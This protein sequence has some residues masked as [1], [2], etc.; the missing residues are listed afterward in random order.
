MKSSFKKAI[1]AFA[2]AIALSCGA[3]GFA[4]CVPKSVD[5]K[6]PSDYDTVT[7]VAAAP[8]DGSLPTAHTAAENLSYICGVFAKQTKYHSYS[9][10]QTVAMGV[11]Q[12]TRSWKDYSDGVLITSDITFSSMVKS[13]TQSC[14]VNYGKDSGT[15]FRTGAKAGSGVLCTTAEWSEEQPTYYDKHSY[16]YTYGMLPTELFNYI[17]NEDTITD[18][19]AATLNS[20]GTY[21]QEFTLD[22]TKSTYYI[23]FAMKTRGGLSGYPT[24]NKVSLTVTFTSSYEILHCSI[25]EN[26][27]LNK[28]FSM[29]SASTYE[30]DYAYGDEAAFYNENVKF[31]E[32]HFAY[33]ESFYKKYVN[34]SSEDLPQGGSSTGLTIDKTNVLANGFSDVLTKAG[35]QFEIFATLGQNKYVGYA[36]VSVP[37]TLDLSTITLRLS[38]GKTLSERGLYIEYSGGA[39]NAYY[40]DDFALAVNLAEV[41]TQIAGFDDIISRITSAV[42]E[43]S[44]ASGGL[45]LSSDAISRLMEDDMTLTAGTSQAIIAL[46]SD[47]L[48][49]LGIGIDAELV[50][51]INTDDIIFRGANVGGISV[52][53]EKLDINLAL[54][55]TTADIISFDGN[56]TP[57]S[58]ADYVADVHRLLSSDLL[59]I[60]VTLNG[61]G[62]SVKIPSLKGL[63]VQASAKVDIGGITL[64]AEAQVSYTYKNNAY[65]CA[66]EVWYGYNAYDE[67]A[68]G[69]GV[70]YVNLK[71]LNGKDVDFKVYCDVENIAS[72]L[73][74]L[75]SAAGAGKNATLAKILNG[76]LSTDF[77]SLIGG[78]YADGGKIQA[79]LSVDTA[80]EM[81]GVD[82]GVSFGTCALT[83]NKATE[84]TASNLFVELPAVGF[85]VTV[86]GAEGEISLPDKGDYLDLNVLLADVATITGAES[87][88]ADIA[89]DGSAVGVEGLAVT[90]AAYLDVS[91]LSAYVNAQVSYGN[92]SVQA[93][94][95]YRYVGKYGEAIISLD[96]VNGKSENLENVKI[97]CN[98][99]DVIPAVSALFDKAQIVS[100]E[101]ETAQNALA[102][103]LSTDFSTLIPELCAGAG[104]LNLTI[105]ADE[106]I[107]ALA[108]E[109]K[110]SA[111]NISLVY[112]H[113]KTPLLSLSA[114]SLGLSVGVN[115]SEATLP[116]FDNTSC[117]NLSDVITDIT[118]IIDAESIRVDITLDGDK[119]GAY[120]LNASVAAYLDVHSK[121][122]AKAEASASYA[123][124][125]STVSLKATAYYLYSEENY[126]NVLL[127]LDSI[128]GVAL[129]NVRVTCGVKEVAEAISA[130]AATIS[131]QTMATAEEGEEETA[132]ILS[133]L[134]SAD[135]SALVPKVSAG[136]KRLEATINVDELL[137][138]FGIENIAV[139]SV[140]LGYNGAE[141]EDTLFAS[142]PAYGVTFA[143]NASDT[144]FEI[145]SLEGSLDLSDVI[146]LAQ[147]AAEEITSIIDSESLSFNIAQNSSYITADGVRASI[148]GGGEVSWKS[149]NKSVK[150]DLYLAID[151]D[152][153][154][155]DITEIKL[156]YS[157]DKELVARVAINDVGLDIYEED[158]TSVKEG[159]AKILAR[160]NVATEG[161]GGLEIDTDSL[162]NLTS[163]DKI[164]SLA[165]SVLAG[166]DWVNI[167]GD[168]T[169]VCD[170][171][172]FALTYLTNSARVSLV[173]G[174]GLALTYLADISDSFSF[175]GEITIASAIGTE[176]D[177]SACAMSS[178]KNG[179]EFARLAYNFLFDAVH[180]ISVENILGANTY[181]VD[182]ELIG[183]NCNISA[184]SGVTVSAHVYVTG[185]D[186]YGKGRIADGELYVD[187]NG[188]GVKLDVITQYD[189]NNSNAYFYINVVQV[190]D[191]VLN[192]KV[193]ASQ[194]SLYLTLKQIFLLVKDTN[195]VDFA[196]K[197]IPSASAAAQNEEEES[198]SEIS[199]QKLADILQKLITLDFNAAIFC[200]RVDDTDYVDVDLNNLIK[201]QLGVTEVGD[202]GTLAFTVD[203]AKHS[204]STEGKAQ[205]V[206][207]D[208][209]TVQK[210]WIKLSSART[211]KKSY[212][213]FDKEDYV[214]IEFL[215]DLIA[216]IKGFAT[217]DGGEVYSSYTLSGSVTVSVAGIID[218]DI[219]ICTL[220]ASLGDGGDAYVSGI[221]H[222]SGKNLV[223]VSIPESTVGFT[224]QGG[225]ITLARGANGKNPEYKIMTTEYFVDHLLSSDDSVLQ[226]WLN[227]SGWSIIAGALTSV[228]VSSGLTEAQ[229][230]YLYDKTETKEDEE[231]SMYSYV[232]ALAVCLGGKTITEFGD[233]STFIGSL[234]LTDNYY[235]FEL[236]AEKITGGV[237]SRL[238]AALLRTES[239]GLTGMAAGG[240]ISGIVTFSATLNY[241]ENPTGE[242]VLGTTLTN[243]VSA[244]SLYNSANAL[245]AAEGH[246]VDYDY[247][248][249]NEEEYYDEIFGCYSIAYSDSAYT[250]TT[251][252]SRMLYG[253]TVTVKYLDGTEEKLT[254]RHGSTLYLYDN[255]SPVYTDESKQ[256]RLLYS[257]ANGSVGAGSVVVDGDITVYAVRREAANI[258][259]YSDNKE[260]KTVTSFVGDSVSAAYGDYFSLTQVTYE[261]G[262]AVADGDKVTS[263]ETLHIYGKF[264]E[265]VYTYNC[266]KYEYDEQTESYVVIG[267][268][269]GFAEK[270]CTGGETLY[271]LSEI[272]GIKVTAIAENAFKCE[273][274]STPLKSV[275]VPASI[276]QVGAGA[277]M[278]NYGL[279]SVVFLGEN[280]T[281]GGSKDEKTMPFYGCS[282]E[283]D[284]ETTSL[285]IYIGSSAN[286]NYDWLHFRTAT[287]WGIDYRKYIGNKHKDGSSA[288][289]YDANAGGAIY[290]GSAW[291]YVTAQVASVDSGD[292]AS[293]LNK[294]AAEEILSRYYPYAMAGEFAGNST[295][296][297]ALEAEFKQFDIVSNSVTYKCVF[298]YTYEKVDGRTVVYYTVSYK[299]AKVIY[300][301]SDVEFTYYGTTVAAGVKTKI[302]YEGELITP[303]LTAY[304]LD[305][306]V[307]SEEDGCAVYTATWSEKAVYS[308]TVK[309]KGYLPNKMITITK[310]DD[311]STVLSKSLSSAA[312]YSFSVYEG[313]VVTIKND[314][315]YLYIYIDGELA[316]TAYSASYTFKDVDYNSG[317]M[318]E[319]ASRECKY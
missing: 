252:Y 58:F 244:P 2:G 296:D 139:G 68:D 278:D 28:G 215:P 188:V 50:F 47:D 3:L 204:I 66:A 222:T 40:G 74:D 220:T 318:T 147:G 141:G 45:S 96:G 72:A 52:G 132:D 246:E 185:E 90:A 274:G 165:L 112:E 196:A 98:I 271:L 107:K 23:Q 209:Q 311:G 289:N 191:K 93:S 240:E 302:V 38:L 92:L 280:V 140:T 213:S 158:I 309:I 86:N 276:T 37:N 267:S 219:D 25:I 95:Q 239:G 227:I 200:E 126:G 79:R 118:D 148:W 111:G 56:K 166:E 17:V 114:E 88:K 39:L 7:T 97:Y 277:F 225:Y 182:F 110:I 211:A 57:Q 270:Y 221:I 137:K 10:G 43:G 297:T 237:L 149:A 91:T 187:V 55:T 157:G 106:L 205:V 293:S 170:G 31:D 245:I 217:N 145:P 159:I 64:G 317:E 287:T 248:V 146:A 279:K 51:G 178:S 231:V 81:L 8:T 134:L 273:E 160:L 62:E 142:L 162:Q 218:L 272:Y 87:I 128:N 260:F 27:T 299:A 207:A 12:T 80:L 193:L 42:G 243:T 316:Y 315:N 117:L 59:D 154:E 49:G 172:S 312:S 171:E 308:F 18:S 9:Y 282:T 151:E 247:C 108:P 133:A 116:D 262:A 206:N 176:V 75:L 268:A 169:S 22:N 11:K 14:T 292:V 294:E 290:E 298:S 256:Y 161:L 250:L 113:G 44:S 70:C 119:L 242:Y 54:K 319:A 121:L 163:N 46:K 234:S 224:Y 138:V 15:Y 174:G 104:S 101:E 286:E 135:Y 291:D 129:D 186:S 194:D 94:A 13:S 168:I 99:S 89:F 125:D 102:G 131:P 264:V 314:G 34:G 258:V 100:G 109:S 105:N 284:G 120:G 61:D 156:V 77:S 124:G 155:S 235:G 216:D 233:T 85:A 83:Y 20:D 238:Y 48:L 179:T 303:A 19:S 288:T 304:K 30:I 229:D 122:A 285:V 130:L 84:N 203:H 199:A 60:G 65:S 253:Q 136:D 197:L 259:L 29:A 36:Y 4:G 69:Y 265:R 255:S 21:S 53:G 16:N 283:L 175:G 269:A 275:V 201:E 181:A 192:L 266:V 76:A 230:V 305:S 281:F 152:G 115:G 189:I 202:L 183:D 24:F 210:T 71:R 144:V 310:A 153:A 150:L 190:A 228:D 214:S 223:L 300:V 173:K 177:F 73:G 6:E 184:L 41:K 82:A 195:V 263:A 306:W 236:N 254:V 226:W 167:L 127:T 307:E 257:A 32:E 180:S 26:S 63:N 78:L 249:K 295:I 251:Q 143:L 164:I 212:T 301:Y 35:Q 1:C 261:G 67:N 313:Q 33:Y 5:L 232:E 123:Y 208:K 103:L 241:V 198:V